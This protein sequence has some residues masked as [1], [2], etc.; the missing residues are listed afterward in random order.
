MS[1]CYCIQVKWWV[2]FCKSNQFSMLFQ[3][4]HMYY[5][6]EMLGNVFAQ[7]MAAQQQAMQAFQLSCRCTVITSGVERLPN[8]MPLTGKERVMLGSKPFFQNTQDEG[9]G[10]WVLKECSC[11]GLS[12]SPSLNL[13]RP[14]AQDPLCP[15][16]DTADKQQPSHLVIFSYMHNSWSLLST[17]WS[18]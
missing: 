4:H 10:G 13:P 16:A 15:H 2:T 17:K 6:V 3:L 12:L 5:F 8:N 9:G 7:W 14:A 18:V 11:P 1:P